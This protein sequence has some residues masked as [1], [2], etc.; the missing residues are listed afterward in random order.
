MDVFQSEHLCVTK[1]MYMYLSCKTAIIST[2]QKT[3]MRSRDDK[4]EALNIVPST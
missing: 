4:R 2:M 1:G 3:K